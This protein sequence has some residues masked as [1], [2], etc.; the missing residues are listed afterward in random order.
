MRSL[1]LRLNTGLLLSL[2]GMFI[3]LWVIVSSAIRHVAQD[4]IATRLSHDSETIISH[5]TFTNEDEIQI[6]ASHTDSIYQRP[7][8]GHYYQIH[9]D[10]KIIYSRS[11]WDTRFQVPLQSSGESRRVMLEGPQQQP[12]LA[13]ISGYTKQDKAIT[14]VVAEDLSRIEADLKDF[15]TRFGLTAL[16]LALLLGLLNI[17]MIR[18]G[19]HPLKRIR[20]E[21]RDLESGERHQLSNVVP[22]EISPL[23]S[24]INHLLQV[25]TT[26]LKRS[27]HSLGDLAHALKKPL[28]ILRQLERETPLTENPELQQQLASQINS[29]QQTID[30]V[31]RRARLA[32]EGYTGVLFNVNN[33]LPELIDVLKKMYRDKALIFNNDIDEKENIFGDREDMLELL[34][35]VLDNACKWATQ[36]IKL[37]IIKND[38]L[39]IIIEDDGVGI[40]ENR[41]NEL[42][43]RG[44][45]L[46]E[47][48]E[49]HGIGLSIVHDI[50]TQYNG[51]I[52][53]GRSVTL[54][55]L[56]VTVSL[57]K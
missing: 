24:E 18:S 42:S 49:G 28:T 48:V 12:L 45:R 4:Y 55:G 57:P 40:D 21:V 11:L 26:R 35:N 30:H 15:Q 46:D 8:S 38:T 44:K 16:V 23:V 52:S 53:Y 3:I 7:F 50:V 20:D 17:F 27:R 36:N 2:L 6:D 9:Y 43:Q 39:N 31:L 14:I 32:G 25:L 54:G 5:I 56:Q 1:Q 37:S 51:T 34:G 10:K 13:V 22:K 29:M 33:D 19:L 47:S 41:I